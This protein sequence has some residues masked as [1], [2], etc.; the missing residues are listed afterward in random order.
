MIRLPPRSTLFPY[1]TLFRSHLRQRDR[2]QRE[3]G[4]LEP[5]GQE[6]DAGAGPDRDDDAED[7][8]EPR[9]LRKP[10]D[11]EGAGVGTDPEERRVADRYLAGV[12]ASH[13]PRRR[14]RSPQENQHETVEEER[15]ADHQRHEGGA[16]EQHDRAGVAREADHHAP[17]VSEPR[18]PKSPAGRNTRTRMKSR[19]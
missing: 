17:R 9:A 4:A 6:A 15:V 16:A 13:V 18:W 10:R 19:K 3:V 7:H 5:I 11:H 1:T 14:Q 8:A 2:G 12:A